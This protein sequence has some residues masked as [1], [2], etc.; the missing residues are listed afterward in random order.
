MQM[1][2]KEWGGGGGGGGKLTF[3]WVGRNSAFV[4]H[5]KAGS[6]SH[7]VIVKLTPHLINRVRAS[8]VKH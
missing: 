1:W 8:I 5:I 4:G 6:A 7:T 3:D 2:E